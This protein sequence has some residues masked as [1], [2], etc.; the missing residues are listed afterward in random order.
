VSGDAPERA[1]SHLRRWF[2][3]A[4]VIALVIAFLAYEV[5]AT[6][7]IREAVRAY[8]ELIAAANRQDLP[9]ARALC[10]DRYL[11]TKTPTLAGEGGIV[12]LPRIIHVNYQAW[13]EGDQIWICPTK[14]VGPVYRFVQQDGAWKFDGL[15]GV[16]RQGVMLSPTEGE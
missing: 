14:G 6:R 5:H 15:V 12:G 3:L 13:R 9:A 16:L 10:T 8:F 11:A 2:L 7:P 1:K 4:G